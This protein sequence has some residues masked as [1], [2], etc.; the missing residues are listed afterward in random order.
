MS[1]TLKKEKRPNLS[2]LKV[3]V[4]DTS[5]SSPNYFKVSDVPQ[6]LPKGK[7]LLRISGNSQNLVEGSQILIDVRDVNGNEI[8]F[9]VPDFIEDNKS[10]VISIWTYHDKGDDNTPNGNARITIV[11]TA[12][13]DLNGN[14]IP[15]QFQNKPNVRWSTSV[16]V[17]RNRPNKSEIIF[18]PESLP[19]IEVS[20]SI[21]TYKDI[22]QGSGLPTKTVVVGT[23]TK[24]MYKGNTP[25]VQ[26][27]T[28]T[29]FVGEM[30]GGILKL[31][32][33]NFITKA[34]PTTSI[35]NP[36][37]ISSYT[38][39]IVEVI[40]SQTVK[41]KTPYSTTFD[42]RV[43]VVHTFTSVDNTRY[44][45]EYY[46][47][48]SYSTT[49]NKR[50]FANITIS[51]SDPMVGVV[52]KIKVLI[53]P[54]GNLDTDYELLNEV[55]V[56][57]S[58]SYSVKIPISSEHLKNVQNL[59]IQYL[60]SIGNIS[61]TK[62]KSDSIAFQG[63]NY[64]FG[65]GENLITGSM[66]LANS[67]GSGIEMAGKSSGYVKSVGF[68]GQTAASLGT[69]PGGFIIYS[70]SSGF[71]LGVDTLEGVGMQMIG[72]NDERHFI[73]TT[74]D[75][76]ALDIKT[77][78][79]FIGTT[80]SQYI[81]ASN[82]NIEISSSR[83]HLQNDGDIIVNKISATQGSI[84]GF[85]ITP[86]A[87][88]SSYEIISGIPALSMHSDGRISGSNMLIQQ[89]YGGTLYSLIDTT[90][91]TIDAKNVGRQIVSDNRESARNEEDD[92]ESYTEI[93]YW[94]ITFLPGETY[95]NISYSAHNTRGSA[96]ALVSGYK[97][98]VATAVTSSVSTTVN[99]YDSWNTAEDVMTRTLTVGGSNIT[100]SIGAGNDYSGAT[101]EIPTEAIGRY[102][103]I[104]LSLRNDVQLGG[105][106]S[107]TSTKIKNISIF[108]SRKYAGDT[109]EGTISG[110]PGGPTP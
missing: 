84:G 104:I 61:R 79:F 102:C 88:S 12:K 31:W 32:G 82:G 105:S 90:A 7:T 74:N 66:F 29:P 41:L 54:D 59:K 89:N 76:G 83:F 39:S 13:F 64:Y 38:S 45:I 18:N 106:S 95:M 96:T 49:E 23:G 50:S 11:G 71:Q 107:G 33:A 47:T 93:K 53:K 9:E 35:P 57:F 97:F 40:D 55:S 85:A 21:E 30:V 52:D 91:G 10:R 63:G 15:K 34:R 24:Y 81:S 8:Y 48:G 56:P 86:T 3:F 46:S 5:L 103:K 73:F 62:T 109:S 69:G 26:A 22:P 87:I 70:G 43:G 99:Y 68:E 78:K 20:E 27:T 98:S 36:T 14:P 44:I 67:I 108:T 19:T 1:L 94:P 4:E 72:D 17:D 60:N 58:S 25:V 110:D 37:N 92:G 42:N 77:D 65:G 6:I 80:G 2:K 101:V 100:G 75:G 16:T 51:G 28:T